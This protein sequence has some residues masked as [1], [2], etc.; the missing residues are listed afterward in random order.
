MSV[1]ATAGILGLAL[2]GL[3]LLGGAA[4]GRGAEWSV[5]PQ[6]RLGGELDSN[7]NFSYRNRQ[8]DFILKA[9]PSLEFSYA[10]EVSRYTGTFALLGQHYLENSGL[11]RVDQRFQLSGR[12][13]V[14]PRLGVTFSGFYVLDTTLQEELTE[15]GFIITRSP[16]QSYGL[17]PGL[18]WQV[19]ER[20]LLSLTYSFGQVN[21]QDPRFTDYTTH[22]A[23][24]GWGHLL[25]D[26]RTTLRGT[27]AGRAVEYSG[28]GNRYRI[29]NLAGGVEHKLAED[30]SVTL[31][32]GVNLTWFTT[33]QAVVEESQFPFFVLVRQQTEKTFS[34][35]PFVELAATRRWPRTSLTGGLSRTES[36]SGGGTLLEYYRGFAGLEHALTERL[37]GGL[38]GSFYYST[39]QQGRTDYENLVLY[40]GSQLSYQLTE[41]LAVSSGYRFGYREDLAGDRSAVRHLWWFSLS[42][43]RPWHSQR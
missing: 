32:A 2:G 14:L 11:D 22:S 1:R 16:R 3:L 41:R 31:L 38:D 27:V 17:A 15:S 8:S 19:T 13:Q 36:A 10:S 40:L 12:R 43:S 28:Q 30:F 37:K 18:T 42:Y 20:D 33:R 29:L 5:V 39:S 7:L 6:I 23:A 34:A 9:W 25:A 4:P 35:R 21:Y 24:L 26:A